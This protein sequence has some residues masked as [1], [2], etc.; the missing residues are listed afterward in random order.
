MVRNVT[1][2]QPTASK[3]QKD[4]IGTS[5]SGMHNKI[6]SVFLVLFKNLF[7]LFIVGGGC[8][9]WYDYGFWRAACHRS[10][11]STMRISVIK[12][13]SSAWRYK[14]LPAE[15]SDKPCEFLSGTHL[16]LRF[17]KHYLISPHAYY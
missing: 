5:E 11:L 3:H 16:Y 12:V 14:P 6:N 17:L 2:Y 9:P 13:K 8:M 1:K 4:K 15:P 10:V 7:Y